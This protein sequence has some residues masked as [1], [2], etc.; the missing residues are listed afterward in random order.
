[1]IE[2]LVVMM[3]ISGIGA[4]IAYIS[5]DKQVNKFVAIGNE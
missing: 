3:L 4:Y 1:M 2:I 5:L